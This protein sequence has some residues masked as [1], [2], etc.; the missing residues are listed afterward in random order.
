MFDIAD[1]C[2]AADVSGLMS[3]VRHPVLVQK[4]VD[5]FD[6]LKQLCDCE[7]FPLE[8]QVC[9]FQSSLFD[10]DNANILAEE[11]KSRLDDV[12]DV[13]VLDIEGDFYVKVTVKDSDLKDLEL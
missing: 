12:F 2:R 7:W 4:S 11:L 8:D 3:A 9:S 6:Y 5:V 10:F 13:S 1:W